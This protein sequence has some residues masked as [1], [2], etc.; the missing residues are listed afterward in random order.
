MPPPGRFRSLP[1]PCTHD[2][3]MGIIAVRYAFTWIWMQPWIKPK[4]KRPKHPNRNRLHPPNQRPGVPRQSQPKRPQPP[5]KP[6]RAKPRVLIKNRPNPNRR[7]KRDS[8]QGP[9]QH[10]QR[11]AY[12]KH[13]IPSQLGRR[14]PARGTKRNSTYPDDGTMPKNVLTIGI[15]F[16]MPVEVSIL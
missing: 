6:H 14:V 10:R 12:P 9:R 7:L 5:A 13:H 4:T 11:P 1:A 2:L 3:A 15:M 16:F 8:N